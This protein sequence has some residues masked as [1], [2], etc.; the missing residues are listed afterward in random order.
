MNHTKLQVLATE[1]WEYSYVAETTIIVFLIRLDSQNHR[2]VQS[3]VNES[4]NQWP[5]RYY[6]ARHENPESCLMQSRIDQSQRSNWCC[7]VSCEDGND[8]ASI[9]ECFWNVLATTK[10]RQ[11]TIEKQSLDRTSDSCWKW[12][13]QLQ[14]IECRLPRMETQLPGN[15]NERWMAG[16]EATTRA[17]ERQHWGLS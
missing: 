10:H 4:I 2:S 1:K 14:W 11:C 17:T 9:A 15:E 16:Q 13:S 8:V 5:K 12:I 7:F 3:L 6:F